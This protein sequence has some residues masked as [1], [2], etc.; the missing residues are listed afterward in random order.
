MHTII[1]NCGVTWSMEHKRFIVG[2]E[3]LLSQG[4]PVRPGAINVNYGKQCTGLA[5]SRPGR[6]VSALHGQAGNSMNVAVA[7]AVFLY[8]AAFSR[9]QG[10]SLALVRFANLR[11]RK[12]GTEDE[13]GIENDSDR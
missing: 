7:G 1:K 13:D 9:G 6:K 2:R 11:M 3:Y 5:C 12:S 8:M 10:A 4:F